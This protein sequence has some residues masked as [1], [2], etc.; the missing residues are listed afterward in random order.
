MDEN[1]KVRV[2]LVGIIVLIIGSLF[3]A[4][5]KK[6]ADIVL[7]TDLGEKY[8]VKET[9]V[10]IHD[11]N[12]M[13]SFKNQLNGEILRNLRD[14]TIKGIA[15]ESRKATEEEIFTIKSYAKEANEKKSIYE[16]KYKSILNKYDDG[17]I[18]SYDIT[19]K[20]IF[21]DINDFKRVMDTKS[22]ICL[23]PLL[24]D[25]PTIAAI[26]KSRKLDLLDEKVCS[27]YAN[28]DLD[29]YDLPEEYRW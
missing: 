5:N 16:Q 21:Q 11:S 29:W 15:D 27:K 28:F 22:V 8:I 18:V 25:I 9:A 4:E 23:N 26:Y 2:F 3:Y 13:F 12:P 6:T 10:A 1:I 19:Y 14:Y 20:P 24:K 7:E 17:F